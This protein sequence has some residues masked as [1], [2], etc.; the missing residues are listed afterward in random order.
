MTRLDRDALLELFGYNE[1]VWQRLVEELSPLGDG[2]LTKPAPGSGW[3]A[4]A[5]CLGHLVKGYEVW[6]NT[7]EGAPR[8]AEDVAAAITSWAELDAFSARV[9]ARFRA[10]LGGLSDEELHRDIAVSVFGEALEYTPAELL[11][12]T[13]VHERGHHGDVNT[14]LY[15]LGLQTGVLDY[16]W[17]VNYKRGYK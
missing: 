9:R 11:A 2:L 17:Y 12:N 5:N 10:V 6:L 3:P 16:R 4:L 8:V 13:V 7:V 14:L 15:Q 1:W